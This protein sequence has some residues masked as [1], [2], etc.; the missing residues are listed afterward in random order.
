MEKKKQKKR[1]FLEAL[2]SA[3]TIALGKE[4]FF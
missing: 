3:I 4:Y 2:P 1:I